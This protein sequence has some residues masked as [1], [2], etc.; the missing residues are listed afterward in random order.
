MAYADFVTALMALFMVMWIGNSSGKVKESVQG[1][2]RD[3]MGFKRRIGTGV[4]NSGE[5]LALNVRTVRDLQSHI[6]AVLRQMPEFHK[7]QKNILFTVTGEGLRIDLLETER[8][9]FF[10]SGSPAPTLAG[11]HLLKV[12]AEELVR[13]PNNVVIEGHTDAQPFRTATPASG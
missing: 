4:A 1:Y 12:L 13:M 11:E 3:P 7:I 5:S 9:M 8:G 2:F 6:E 10:S